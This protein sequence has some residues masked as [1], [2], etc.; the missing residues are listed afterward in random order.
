MVF[1]SLAVYTAAILAV[2]AA[3]FCGLLLATT[4]AYL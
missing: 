4:D 2:L 1:V 3:A